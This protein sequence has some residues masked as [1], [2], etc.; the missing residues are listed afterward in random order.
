MNIYSETLQIDQLIKELIVSGVTFSVSDEKLK[1]T[2]AG[3][4]SADVSPEHKEFI[5]K[6]KS[7]IKAR[8]RE[9]LWTSLS[10]E[11]ERFWFLSQL[12]SNS[13]NH[14]SGFFQINGVVNVQVL[15]LSIKHLISRHP[16]LRASYPQLDGQPIQVIHQSVDFQLAQ[17]EVFCQD[18]EKNDELIA[19]CQSF[20]NSP[21]DLSAAPLLRATLFR[22]SEKKFVLGICLHHIIADGWS[23]ELISHELSI[24][25]SSSIKNERPSLP[26]VQKSYLDFI[27]WQKVQIHNGRYQNQEA[28]W[29]QALKNYEDLELVTD[30]HRP[31]VSSGHGHTV[32][33]TIN[34]DTFGNLKSFCQERQVTTFSVLMAAQFLLLRLYSGQ[35]DIC[36]GLP[37]ANRENEKLH[38]I[39][40]LFA[41]TLPIRIQLKRTDQTVGDFIN[42]I[43]N[44]IL[45]GQQNP[46]LP[47]NKIVEEISPDRSL[48][49]T[50]IFQVLSNY[51]KVGKGGRLRLGDVQLEPLSFNNDAS[52]FDLS[53]D[54]SEASDELAIQLNCSRDLFRASTASK[55]AD[56]FQWL[57]AQLLRDS[58]QKIEDLEVITTY[59]LEKI[60]AW[61]TTQ[62]TYKNKDLVIGQFEK[63]AALHP[64]TTALTFE[65]K[66]MTYQEL[67]KTSNAL[68][69][70]LVGCGIQKNDAVGLCVYR[71]FEMMVAIFAIQ[72]AGAAYLPV[73]PDFPLERIQYIL[74]DSGASMLLVQNEIQE[75]FKSSPFENLIEAMPSYV[76]LVA[77]GNYNAPEISILPEDISYVI[78][79][80]GST[81]MPKGVAI[82]HEALHNR[83]MWMQTKY[84]LTERDMIM[85]KTPFTFD[86]SVWEI[87]WWSISDSQLLLLPPG[88]EKYPDQLLEA[89][90]EYPVTV[91]HFVPSML[92]AFLDYMGSDTVNPKVRNLLQVFSSGEA[93]TFKHVEDFKKLL[94]EVKLINLYGPTEATIDVSFY[95]IPRELSATTVPIGKPI[96]NTELYVLDRNKK[97]QPIGV[98]GELYIGGVGLAKGYL[99]KPELTRERFIDSPFSS[100]ERLYRTGDL[101]KW[102]DNGNIEFLGRTDHQVKIRGYRIE[103]NEIDHQLGQHPAIKQAVTIDRMAKGSHSLV[104]FYIASNTSDLPKHEDLK[105][106]LKSKLPDYMVP[107][108]FKAID[109]F[110][111]T[112][113]GK[114][115]RS[116]LQGFK[117]ESEKTNTHTT[118]LSDAENLVFE[119]WKDNLVEQHFNVDDNFFE[120]GGHSLLAVKIIARINNVFNIRLSVKSIF[121]HPT[122]KELCLIIAQEEK[123]QENRLKHYDVREA[124]MSSAQERLW[125]LAKSGQAKMY[126]LLNTL[127][128]SGKLNLKAF[129]K[130]VQFLIQ[131][132]QSFRTSFVTQEDLPKQVILDKVEFTLESVD[133]Q[134][135]ELSE[136]EH[137][138]NEYIDAISSTEFDLS[139]PPL[140]RVAVVRTAENEN[141]VCFCIHHIISDAWS[142]DIWVRELEEVYQNIVQN[143]R[144]LLTPNSFEYIDYTIWQKDASSE[145]AEGLNFWKE[146]LQG[147]EDLELSLDFE[148]NKTPTSEGGFNLF[149][150][151]GETTA[152][153]MNFFV[154]QELTVFSVILTSIYILLERHSGQKDFC[155]GVPVVNR[156]KEE[157]QGII[158]FFVNTLPLRIKTEKGPLKVLEL[159][160][161]VQ[162]TIL[163]S[164]KHQHVPFDQIVKL[165][166]NERNLTVSPIFQVVANYTKLVVDRKEFAGMPVEEIKADAYQ[167][168]VDLS[169]NFVEKPNRELWVN[170]IYNKSIYTADTI[171]RLADHLKNII[172]TLA[173]HSHNDFRSLD[174]LTKNEHELIARTNNTIV[175]LPE[176]TR[177]HKLFEQ[178]ASRFFDHTAVVCND[179]KI[180]YS[181]LNNVSNY[182]ARRIQEINPAI[183]QKIGLCLDRSIETVITILAILKSGN[184][185]VSI[186]PNYPDSRKR[187][188]LDDCSCS[189]V[190]CHEKSAVTFDQIGVTA[191]TI[192]EWESQEMDD[193]SPVTSN[194]TSRH[195]AYVI[196]TS[197]T[198]GLPK[199][200][201]VSHKS[202]ANMAL[203]SVR[204]LTISPEDNISQF[205]STSF[206][207][208]VKEMF[209]TLLAGA[210][211]VII[212]EHIK[213]NKNRF[214]QYFQS[215]GIS[216]SILPPPYLSSLEKNEDLHPRVLITGGEAPKLSDAKFYASRVDHY[217]AYGPTEIGVCASYYKIEKDLSHDIVPIGKP[218]DNTSMYVLNESLS[219]QP[220]N[221]VGE[222]YISG[223]G[224]AL[225]YLNDSDLTEARFQKDPF[226]ANRRMYKTGDLAL[227]LPDGNIQFI[228]RQDDQVKV[229]GHRIELNEIQAVLEQH[230]LVRL[231]AVIL[232]KV[233]NKNQI[234]GF[235]TSHDS[236]TGRERLLPFLQEKLPQ[237]MIPQY[238]MRLEDMPL[239]TNLKID[240]IALHNIPLRKSVNAAEHQGY[241]EIQ[242]TLLSIWQD[243]LKSD[244]IGLTD[245]FF[246][247]GGDSVSSIMI[248]SKIKE[249]LG[250][251]VEIADLF[252]L[253]N[254][255]SLSKHIE[256]KQKGSTDEILL[257][258]WAES[259][260]LSHAQ[261]RFWI[262]DALGNKTAGNVVGMDIIDEAIDLAAFKQAYLGCVERHEILRTTFHKVDGLPKQR[263]HEFNSSQIAVVYEDISTEENWERRALQVRGKE[264][265]TPFD[266]THSP[267]TRF[268]FLKIPDNKHISLFTAHHI[269]MDGWSISV[270]R[271]E[272]AKRYQAAKQKREVFLEPLPIQY[273]DYAQWH[274]DKIKGSYGQEALNYW[275]K[276]FSPGERSFDFTPDHHRSTI[277]S[278]DGRRFVKSLGQEK[279]HE[280]NAFT[281]RHEVSFFMFFN[282]IVTLI[283]H[284]IT[285]EE[286]ITVRTPFHGRASELLKDQI[287][288]YLNSLPLKLRILED[289]T[290]QDVLHQSREVSLNAFS[291]QYFPIDKLSEDLKIQTPQGGMPFSNVVVVMQNKSMT[292]RTSGAEASALASSA[293]SI[294]ST[295]DLRIEFNEVKD[296]IVMV[297][298][299][300]ASLF[301]RATVETLMKNI[302]DVATQVVQEEHLP[303]HKI[304]TSEVLASS[305]EDAPINPAFDFSF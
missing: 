19:L 190:F 5:G 296:D 23:L 92:E 155:I 143:E 34:G 58:N 257:L 134:A 10:A 305:S 254:I 192:S 15:E 59:D 25:Y 224:V 229:L 97:H 250:V 199:G 185:Y 261:K 103:L 67:N 288:L 148:R 125:F 21:F 175:Q 4:G 91:M 96:A 265:T 28:F 176:E 60:T 50:P 38:Q 149:K 178:Q 184:A 259:Y 124:P 44:Q 275:K 135:Y 162:N 101:A 252:A 151:E 47:F 116:Y 105:S 295:V 20:L 18:P 173:D 158:G 168:K 171:S 225:E 133:L 142:L 115:N 244:S 237:Y 145:L 93:L 102:N 61:N 87:F 287:G 79:T 109:T 289:H 271:E 46:N 166:S 221:A 222:L 157:F 231:A 294:L 293:E 81:G 136:K 152:K 104:T 177:M 45:R 159:L 230:P 247:L 13:A 90:S 290:F 42:Y 196:Y 180:S 62:Q 303:V 163:T 200:V 64:N 205:A 12:S 141:I 301:E 51:A 29:K 147:Y 242:S 56:H 112:A 123:K 114:L 73:D 161:E 191:L 111:L 35:D 94:P 258:P 24:I 248:S 201:V 286:F 57:L 118:P 243:V 169:F 110:P 187:F 77:Q 119:I 100:G 304:V 75:K 113:S 165:V 268:V 226:H 298:D 223:E 80:S 267:L 189:V 138:M 167:A 122:I 212:P 39:V 211:L 214:I 194:V 280:M 7:E 98:P 164:Q 153:L 139:Q 71:S 302:F 95:D 239:T 132:H 233:G 27:I 256:K 33:A 227:R 120:L 249:Q 43:Q 241:S 197:G 292:G 236:S 172:C 150:I 55:I 74:E 160:K 140:I 232:K 65:G 16:T 203:D 204:R 255:L 210:T 219:H 11:Q 181:T 260:E 85:Q 279:W 300:N 170:L 41:N 106:Y 174:I 144:A 108:L 48:S 22:T 182:Y 2:I 14:I 269:I 270:F 278:A 277:G 156:E 26:E 274:S 54:Y 70:L 183:G 283:L 284:K 217:N 281:K 83:L 1:L 246:D 3:E 240:S 228:G 235:F 31:G 127:R 266:L 131:R 273:K 154:Q 291:Y 146:H 129:E 37:V 263:V 36:L 117:L 179:G 6:Y 32:H 84:P 8:I 193:Q 76:E 130:A 215:K 297:L 207:V 276:Q 82:S 195:P 299:Y 264:M 234:A 206:D 216:I 40:G 126:N 68:A 188:I 198:T 89:I 282:A 272:L 86:V 17:K 88:A 128:I 30:F 251:D 238:L 137:R 208:S 99:N 262:M 53:F 186:D 72:K 78:Y 121:S 9:N 202:C 69:Q 63:R 52:R 107:V 49:K 218:I 213:S 220:I 253:Q 66:T 245:N 209:I 285:G